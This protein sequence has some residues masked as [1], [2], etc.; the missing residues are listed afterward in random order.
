MWN[1]NLLKGISKIQTVW[2]IFDWL[3]FHYFLQLIFWLTLLASAAKSNEKLVN[4]KLCNTV[5][6]LDALY[7]YVRWFSSSD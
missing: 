1:G 6:I 3:I 7:M 4:Q 2:Y 5:L